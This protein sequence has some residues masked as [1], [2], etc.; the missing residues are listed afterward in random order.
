MPNGFI[1]ENVAGLDYFDIFAIHNVSPSHQFT[2]NRDNFLQAPIDVSLSV[3]K[4]KSHDLITYRN[5]EVEFDLSTLLLDDDPF[6][7]NNEYFIDLSATQGPYDGT[8]VL[9][10]E[11]LNPLHIKYTPASDT[12]SSHNFV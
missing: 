10:N 6:K 3:Y 4:I 5:T 11:S 12:D 7:A 2:Y 9:V 8:Y 1:L